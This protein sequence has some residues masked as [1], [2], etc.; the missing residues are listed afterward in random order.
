MFEKDI[1]ITGKHATF[2]KELAGQNSN[3]TVVKVFNRNLDLLMAAPL[4]GAIY[5]K[6]AHC[7]DGTDK[8]TILLAQIVGEKEKLEHIHRI[9]LLRDKSKNRTN[10]EK[11]DLAF[12]HDGDMELFM[13]YVRG[14]IEYL[15]DSLATN[16]TTRDD[17]YDKLIEMLRNIK[18]YIQVEI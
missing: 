13:D 17:C 8:S 14:G 15:Y 12:R 7:H 4:V 9:V 10:D 2:M 3:K 18:T 1:V 11:V 5:N 6:R 16:T